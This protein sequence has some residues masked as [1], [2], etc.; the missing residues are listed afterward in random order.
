MVTGELKTTGTSD[1]KCIHYATR[2]SLLQ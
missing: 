1:L 2:V